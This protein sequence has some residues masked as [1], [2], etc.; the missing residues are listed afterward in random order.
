MVAFVRKCHYFLVI[1]FEH[2][3]MV[4]FVGFVRRFRSLVSFVGFV[5]FVGRFRYVFRTDTNDTYQ[6]K[7]IMK[8]TNGTHRNK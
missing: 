1:S 6:Q 3:I 7:K 5:G 8:P 2:E 4:P